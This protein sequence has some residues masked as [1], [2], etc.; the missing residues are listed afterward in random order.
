MIVQF[1]YGEDGVDVSRRDYASPDNVQRLI[2]KILE[3]ESA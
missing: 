2:K 1:K 3:K